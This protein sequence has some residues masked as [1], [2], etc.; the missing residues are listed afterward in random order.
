M[1]VCVCVFWEVPSLGRVMEKKRAFSLKS[2]GGSLCGRREKSPSARHRKGETIAMT[3]GCSPQE[4]A[5]EAVWGQRYRPARGGS[6][7][8][9]N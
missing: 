6:G 1:C 9:V 4:P 5:A 7:G 8:G 3:H 2:L